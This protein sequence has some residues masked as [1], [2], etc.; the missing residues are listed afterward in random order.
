MTFIPKW[1]LKETVLFIDE[2]ETQ[3]KYELFQKNDGT[4]FVAH[5]FRLDDF[6]TLQL[7]VKIDEL[8][9]LSGRVK[10]HVVDE[11]ELHF[12]EKILHIED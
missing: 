7:W 9:Y 2:E 5:L 3:Y 12:K 8:N 6:M 1:Y 4:G 10:E 11:V